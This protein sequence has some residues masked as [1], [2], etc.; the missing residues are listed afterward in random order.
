MIEL[1]NPEINEILCNAV[2]IIEVHPPPQIGDQR[3]KP[4]EGKFEAGPIWQGSQNLLADFYRYYWRVGW[5]RDVGECQWNA[6]HR[7]WTRA[8]D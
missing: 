4:Y 5:A 6:E 7:I 1:N 8:L 2:E 3:P